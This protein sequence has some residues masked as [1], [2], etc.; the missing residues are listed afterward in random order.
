MIHYSGGRD[1][2][3]ETTVAGHDRMM[4][5]L[6]PNTEV[7]GKSDWERSK[8]DQERR[9]RADRR[10]KY[11]QTAETA[12]KKI[13]R[14]MQTGVISRDTKMHD[15]MPERSPLRKAPAKVAQPIVGVS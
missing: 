5:E 13:G 9:E 11:E 8:D 15:P 12:K 2:F 14:M 7:W 1:R 3:H 6:N 10:R 4:R